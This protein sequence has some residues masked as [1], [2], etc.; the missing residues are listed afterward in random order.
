MFDAA[1]INRAVTFHSNTLNNY[2][3]LTCNDSRNQCGKKFNGKSVGGYTYTKTHWLWWDWHYINMYDI[4]F[5]GVKDFD[6]RVNE[7][8]DNVGNG[9][10]Q[11][12]DDASWLQTTG[13]YLVHEMMHS[14]LIDNSPPDPHSK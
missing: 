4:F 12:A 5:T 14:K 6:E 7:I 9:N 11:Y 1:N 10:Y 8:R 3:T 2:I 13:S